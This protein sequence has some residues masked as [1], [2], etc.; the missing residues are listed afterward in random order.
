MGPRRAAAWSWSDSRAVPRRTHPLSSRPSPA[1]L[2][3]SQRAAATRLVAPMRARSMRAAWTTAQ[4]EPKATLPPWPDA[5]RAAAP[6]RRPQ[7]RTPQ[8]RDAAWRAAPR[9]TEPAVRTTAE[10]PEAEC[11]GPQRDTDDGP[12]ARAGS[13]ASLRT[14]GGAACASRW[15]LSA[16]QALLG[17]RAAEPGCKRKCAALGG[18]L[19]SVRPPRGVARPARPTR[20]LARRAPRSRA[21]WSRARRA[22]GAAGGHCQ[23]ARHG[24]RGDRRPD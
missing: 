9:N 20:A 11:V 19:P 4:R 22:H 2:R 21:L 14:G 7:P 10:R 18:S 1:R 16:L 24:C 15:P 6:T 13:G 23:H 8:P 12:T 5:I 17:G 3:R